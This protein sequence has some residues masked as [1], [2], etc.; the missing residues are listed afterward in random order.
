MK[1]VSG[2]YRSDFGRRWMLAIARS[3]FSSSEIEEKLGIT[4][5]AHKAYQSNRNFPRFCVLCQFSKTT[6][7]NLHWLLLGEGPMDFPADTVSPAI[8]PVPAPHG[9]RIRA[10]SPGGS[11]P[12]G[13]FPDLKAAREKRVDEKAARNKRRHEDLE[14]IRKIEALTKEFSAFTASRPPLTEQHPT[15][16]DGAGSTERRERP[17][18]ILHRIKSWFERMMK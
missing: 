11:A 16:D 8:L 10:T 4:P 5:R 13:A 9:D 2:W 6:G 3:D 17:A 12:S 7:V 1:N 15:G 18:L 14:I